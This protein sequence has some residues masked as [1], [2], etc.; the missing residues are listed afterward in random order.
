MIPLSTQNI[1]YARSEAKVDFRVTNHRRA[2][3]LD[4][5]F[6]AE[7]R[8]GGAERVRPR[9]GGPLNRLVTMDRWWRGR[10]S[11]DGIGT[12]PRGSNLCF[13]RL[14]TGER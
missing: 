11:C 3:S 12:E 1:E 14:R 4:F 5:H 10:T 2:A 7:G 9:R 6:A 8:P 13:V